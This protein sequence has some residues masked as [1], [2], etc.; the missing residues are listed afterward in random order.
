MHEQPSP[1]WATHFEFYGPVVPLQRVKSACVG[2]G[3]RTIEWLLYERLLLLQESSVL[4]DFENVLCN[5]GQ[6]SIIV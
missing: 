6:Q 5:L 4:I 1:P 3:L 2:N